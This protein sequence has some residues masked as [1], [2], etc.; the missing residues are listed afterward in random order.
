MD[1]K[2][3]LKKIIILSIILNLLFVFI[4]LFINKQEYRAYLKNYNNKI[5]I[6][7]NNI[8]EKFPDLSDSEIFEIVTSDKS[9]NNFFR[10]YGYDLKSDS[11][12]EEN[13]NSFKKYI[14]IEVVIFI[15]NVS[16]IFILY[17]TYNKKKDNEIKKV[18]RL[19]DNIN[20]RNYNLDIDTFSEEE[21]SILK[22]EIYKITVML[23]EQADNSNKDKINLKTSLEDISHQLRTPLTAI[24]INIDNIL[25]N[26]NLDD[27]KKEE[28][29]RKIKRESYNMKMLI[30][31]ILKLSKFEVNTISFNRKDIYINDLINS[32]VDNVSTLADLKNISIKTNGNNYLFK[33]DYSWEVEAL[34]NILKNAVEH[35]Y[36]DSEILINYS[37]NKVYSK[38]EIINYGETI[39]SE[40]LKH[41]FERFYKGKNSKSDSFGIGLSLAKAIVENDNGK[42][43]VESF[44]NKTIFTIKYYK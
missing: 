39:L 31:L 35:A 19:V 6:I 13:S 42:I 5:N 16:L 43:M 44:D 30:E 10:K 23:R 38:I 22:D 11:I 15:L 24:L 33:C 40:D 4:F 12:I 1:N 17:L 29:L 9:S 18:I 20:K 21:L 26:P 36:S 14:I 7:S 3:G 8:K 32:V 34:T 27:K 41:I 28:F 2:P 25:D 37:D